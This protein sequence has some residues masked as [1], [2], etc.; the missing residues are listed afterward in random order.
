MVRAGVSLDDESV[1]ET[2]VECFDTIR[3]I[4]TIDSIENNTDS[5]FPGG[6]VAVTNKDVIKM[7]FMK[8]WFPEILV[9]L[10]KEKNINPGKAV[11]VYVPKDVR[12]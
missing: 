1:K 12:A 4:S 6:W 9:N 5:F 2:L 8:Y 10:I 7:N 3:H 11:L